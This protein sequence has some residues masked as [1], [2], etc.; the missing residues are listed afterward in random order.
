M[1]E[2]YLDGHEDRWALVTTKEFDNPG[3][4]FD[5]YT[6][7]EDVE[8]RHRQYKCFWDLSKFRSTDFSLVANQIIYT[9]MTYSFLQIHLRLRDLGKINHQTIEAI[10][11]K[12]RAAQPK[13][14]IYYQD[15]VAFLTIPHYTSLLLKLT[16][17]ARKRILR[18]AKQMWVE[19]LEV[20][21]CGPIFDPG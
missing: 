18:R 15:R 17:K 5:Y 14:I 8:E 2:E 9:L 16:E 12:L 6:I 10:K 11:R 4:P 21:I 20:E 13:V 7:R 3:E 19:L 1:R